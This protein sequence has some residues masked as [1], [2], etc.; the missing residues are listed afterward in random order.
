MIQAS[1]AHSTKIAGKAKVRIGIYTEDHLRHFWLEL[2]EDPY[3]DGSVTI[4]KIL[5]L[6]GKRLKEMVCVKKSDVHLD[7]DDP[8]WFLPDTKNGL[9][10]DVPLTVTTRA[11]FAQA[12]A[13]AGNSDYV[14]SSRPGSKRYPWLDPRGVTRQRQRILARIGIRG[15]F[16]HYMRRNFSLEMRRL[17]V[18][19]DVRKKLLNHAPD[20]GD[21]TAR[22]YTPLDFWSER[23]VEAYEQ[24][25]GEIIGQPLI[26]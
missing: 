11:L 12:F 21:I 17:G 9:P 20:S 3:V 2:S 23:R 8:W 18:R 10:D 5:A 14:F 16:T 13:A 6:T 1:P 25:L 19:D 24:R 7:G 22:Y 4:L 15:R 26:S